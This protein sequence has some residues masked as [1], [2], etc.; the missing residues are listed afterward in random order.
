MATKHDENAPTTVRLLEIWV[1]RLFPFGIQLQVAKLN[2]N[3]SDGG[4]F[5]LWCSNGGAVLVE[6]DTKA[7]IIELGDLSQYNEFF[8]HLV[9]KP[10]FHGNF[11]E[12]PLVVAQVKTLFYNKSH[13]DSF[14]AL[15]TPN[16]VIL[17]DVGYQVWLWRLCNR[18]WCVPFFVRWTSYL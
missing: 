8:K 17:F 16:K 11:S 10:D 12:M 13:L 3:P 14:E 2:L 1:G 5:N 9:Y 18:Y 4:K 15:S 6:A 7:K